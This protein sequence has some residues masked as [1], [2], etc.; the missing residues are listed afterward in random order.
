MKGVGWASA[1]LLDRDDGLP[2][3]NTEKEKERDGVKQGVLVWKKKGGWPAG[4][5][6]EKLGFGPWTNYK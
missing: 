2:A 4:L 3:R 1:G 5:T 6:Q